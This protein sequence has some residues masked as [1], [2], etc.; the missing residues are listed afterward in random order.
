MKLYTLPFCP[1]CE[2]AKTKLDELGASYEVIC[3]EEEARSIGLK[4]APVLVSNSG[5]QYGLKE[6]ISICKG[7]GFFE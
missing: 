2:L 6:I 3:N 5:K 1:K 4:V 7:D